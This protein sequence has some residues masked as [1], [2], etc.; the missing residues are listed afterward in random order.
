MF[1]KNEKK[2]ENREICCKVLIVLQIL[3]IFKLRCI[4][5]KSPKILTMFQNNNSYQKITKLGHVSSNVAKST[6]TL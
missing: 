2:I 4:P 3:E 1:Q 6:V 5:S